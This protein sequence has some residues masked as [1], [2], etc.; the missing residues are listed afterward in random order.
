MKILRQSHHLYKD[1]NNWI[2]S[3]LYVSFVVFLLV[4]TIWFIEQERFVYAWDFATYYDKYIDLGKLVYTDIPRLFTTVRDSLTSDYSDLAAIPLLPL[5]VVLGS[6][7]VAYIISLLITYGFPSFFLFAYMLKKA[8]R[9]ITN[10]PIILAIVP[11]VAFFL[12]PFIML[13]L[14]WGYS[15]MYGVGLICFIYVYYYLEHKELSVVQHGAL[16]LLLLLF[17]LLRRWYGY[18]VISFLAI[19]F[20]SQVIL[21]FQKKGAVN[22]IVRLIG[23][24]L[25]TVSVFIGVGLLVARELFVR[26]LLTNYADMYSA[27]RNFPLTDFWSTLTINMGKLPTLFLLVGICIGVY[28][29]KL[30]AFSL[31]MLIQAVIVLVWFTRTQNIHDHMFYL[32]YPALLF[33]TAISITHIIIACK[34]KLVAYVF[35]A[36]LL[37]YGVYNFLGVYMPG[38]GGYTKSFQFAFSQRRHY[39]MVRTDLS[40]LDRL[41]NTLVGLERRAKGSI[42]VLS[43]VH[44]FNDDMLR[45]YCLSQTKIKPVCEMMCI[46]SGIDKRDGFPTQLLSARYVLVRDPIDSIDRQHIVEDLS[47]DFLYQGALSSNFDKLPY[48]FTLDDNSRVYVFSKRSSIPDDVIEMLS[49]CYQIHFKDI[50]HKINSCLPLV[51]TI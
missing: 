50:I 20:V 38:V 23:K 12:N 8:L 27:Y 6:T 17:T 15:V 34:R 49:R 32:F 33:F 43:F 19:L 48:Q 51:Q 42:Y 21:L 7:R 46:S 37:F 44:L 28:R 24:F 11:M 30:R 16:G 26:V 9:G 10:D 41:M 39:P 18:W 40:E 3:V 31:F 2:R 14:Y 22:R 1:H 35:S 36:L 4:F 47:A 25:V 5:R 13:P 45:H 29:Y